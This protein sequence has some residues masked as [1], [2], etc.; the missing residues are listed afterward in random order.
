VTAVARHTVLTVKNLAAGMSST[1]IFI[2]HQLVALKGLRF[3]RFGNTFSLSAMFV[4]KSNN[5]IDKYV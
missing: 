1:F 4:G 3:M 2:Q 5:K